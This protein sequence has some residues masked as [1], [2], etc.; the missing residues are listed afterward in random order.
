MVFLTWTLS[1][2][3]N[4][5]DGRAYADD[6]TLSVCSSSSFWENV[7]L[8]NIATILFET[9]VS[10]YLVKFSITTGLWIAQNLLKLSNQIDRVKSV[11]S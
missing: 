9:F 2:P 4:H 7:L 8:E 1:Y 3:K 10:R 6:L 5:F 11:Q